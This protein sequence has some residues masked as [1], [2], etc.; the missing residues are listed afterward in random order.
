[1]KSLDHYLALL[2]EDQR[3]QEVT[4]LL[5]VILEEAEAE[6]SAAYEEGD[7]DGYGTGH[8]DGYDEGYADGK[9]ECEEKE[10]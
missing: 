1:M 7:R 8:S 4:D 5:S 10:D 3:T 2:P 9:K 6:F